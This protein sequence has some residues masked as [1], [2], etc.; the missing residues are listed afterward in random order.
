[1]NPADLKNIVKTANWQNEHIHSDEVQAWWQSGLRRC[2]L[3]PYPVEYH[4]LQNLTCPKC[5]EV[6]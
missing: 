1:M 3:H 5:N 6:K 4:L 2:E